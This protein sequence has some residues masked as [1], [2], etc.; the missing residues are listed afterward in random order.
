MDSTDSKKAEKQVKRFVLAVTGSH[1]RGDKKQVYTE[2]DAVYKTRQ[3]DLLAVGDADQ[4]DCFA[5][6]WARD[7]GI[8]L[9]VFKANWALHGLDAGPIRNQ[10]MLDVAQPDLL[11]SFPGGPGTADCTRRA[12]EMGIEVKIVDSQPTV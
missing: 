11:L 4:I 6:C 3:I 8:S 10:E 12:R 9:R 5:R 1:L 2:L 7:R